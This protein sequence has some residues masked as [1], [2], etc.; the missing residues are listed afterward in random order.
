MLL[1][2]G[3]IVFFVGLLITIVTVIA[4][5]VLLYK[6]IQNWAQACFMAVPLGFVLMFAGLSTNIFLE[7]RSTDKN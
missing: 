7:P 1:L 2:L 3:R 5:F 6:D 4:G